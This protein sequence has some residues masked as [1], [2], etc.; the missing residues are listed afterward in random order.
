MDRSDRVMPTYL[1]RRIFL[2]RTG[3]LAASA[4][5]PLAQSSYSFASGAETRGQARKVIILGAGMSGLAA[6]LQLLKD[7][8]EVTIMEARTRPGGRVHTIREPLSDGLHVE[9]GAGRIPVTHQLT[10]EYTKRFGLKLDPF[11]PESGGKV[12]L[13][14][15]KRA[16]VPYGQAPD[17]KN[18]ATNFTEQE[19]QVGF[20][21]LEKLYLASAQDQIRRLP[22]AGWP[23]PSQ[24]TWGK[25]SF[26]EFLKLQGA[27]DDAVEYLSEGFE[28]DSALDFLHD[29]VSHAVPKLWKIRG[30]NDLL[31]KA[32]ATQLKEQIRYGA[33]VVRISQDM[34]GVAVRFRSGANN[35]E[36]KGDRL[37][38]T[39]PFSVLRDIEVS[40]PWSDRKAGAI[41]SMY[42]G[43]VTRVYIQ[44]RTRFWE[45]QGLNGFASVDRPMELWSPSFNQPGTRGIVMS[46]MYERMAREFSAL[47]E[48]DR[49]QKTLELFEQVHPGLKEEFETATTWS[50]ADEKYSRG[51]FMVTRPGDSQAI[52]PYAGSVEGRIHFAG[53][54]TSPWP[55]WMQG[56][57]HSGLRVA[58]EVTQSLQKA[59]NRQL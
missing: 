46:Y 37:I 30:G 7:G 35:H 25:I 18:F 53:E 10:L 8:H 1:D 5:L 36:I 12:F 48:T 2:K 24:P 27:S 3:L 49:I 23:H 31:P 41:R 51:A 29:S 21:G 26:R 52:L 47:N 39:L 43:P 56:A 13:W 40:P 14:R 38:C 34:A 19:R 45:K 9:A 55:G 15:G 33:E 4:V 32:M 16:I 17:T 50:W 20:D 58:S 6:G 44:S 59:I 11:Y 57:L 42:C 22:F 54:H 28:D